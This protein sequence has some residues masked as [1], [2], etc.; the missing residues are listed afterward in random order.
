MCYSEY[1]E[2]G[3][4]VKKKNF[5]VTAHTGCENTPQNS[6]ESV[7]KAFM[8]GADIFEIDIRFDKKGTPLLS[9]DEPKGNEPLLDE[10]FSVFAKQKN[11]LCNLDLKCTDNLKEISSVAKKHGVADRIFYTGVGEDF[12]ERVKTDT[13][14]IPY[15]LNLSLKPKRNHTEKYISSVIEKVKKSGAVG[16]NCNY[17]NVTK[18]LIDSF[19]KNNLQFSVWTV[20]K[21]KLMFRFAE[22]NPDNITTRKPSLLKEIASGKKQKK[23]SIFDKI[24]RK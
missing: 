19:H 4:F 3:D 20:D 17:K 24:F 10:I 22:M 21:E 11:I 14:E 23:Q 7:K 15:F 12:V 1:I 13:P 2:R 6:V 16:I 8:S 5:T 9:H 18:E